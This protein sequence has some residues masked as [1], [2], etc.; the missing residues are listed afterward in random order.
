MSGDRYLISDQNALYFL[1]FTVV[2][3]IDVFTRKEYKLDIVDSLNYCIQSKGLTIY[4]W[5][6]M[7]NH[8]HLIVR[9]NEGFRLSDIIRDLKKFTAKRI[10]DRIENELESRREWMLNQFRFAGRNLKRITNFKFWKDDNHVIE[11]TSGM[12]DGRLDYIHQNPVK[13]MIVEEPEHYLFSSARD[14]SGVKGLVKIEF[15]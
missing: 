7:S 15:I 8:L 11:L 6:L 14:Y 4:S 13:A 12:I 5:C 3:W 10:I 2:G 1:T 9:A